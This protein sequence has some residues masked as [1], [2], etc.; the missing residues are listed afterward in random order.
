MPFVSSLRH[1]CPSQGRED[2]VLYFL[3]KD[4]FTFLIKACDPLWIN[5]CVKYKLGVKVNFFP[6]RYPM[7][8]PSFIARHFSPIE[9]QWSVCCKS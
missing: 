1:S 9:E 3:I 6:S 7:T 2:I 5:F 4:C 8:P